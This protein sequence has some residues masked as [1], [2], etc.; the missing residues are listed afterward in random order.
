[1]SFTRTHGLTFYFPERGRVHGVPVLRRLPV[2]AVPGLQ[3]QQEVRPSQRLHRGIRRSQVREMRREWPDS[4]PPLLRNPESV[5]ARARNDVVSVPDV[6]HPFIPLLKTKVLREVYSTLNTLTERFSLSCQSKNQQIHYVYRTD[7]PCWRCLGSNFLLFHFRW[8]F[9]STLAMNHGEVVA[10]VRDK[11]APARSVLS[12]EH[13][14][15]T[16]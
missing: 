5:L 4:L 2:A 16:L 3:R 6:S 9:H 15:R 10:K 14:S 1:M 11:T 12:T 7:R 13:D 8:N